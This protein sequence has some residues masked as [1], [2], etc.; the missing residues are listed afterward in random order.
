VP[1]REELEEEKLV[2]EIEKLRMELAERAKVQ[3]WEF[4]KMIATVVGT[5]AAMT[6]ALTALA[7][8]ILSRL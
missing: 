5:T 4:A 1:S 2:L 7:T 8:F 6:I 3:R